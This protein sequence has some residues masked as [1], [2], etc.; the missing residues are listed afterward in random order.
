MYQGEWKDGMPHGNG[1]EFY[2][3]TGSLRYKGQFRETNWDGF[4]K[5]YTADGRKEIKGYWKDSYLTD[6]VLSKKDKESNFKIRQEDDGKIYVGQLDE[7]GQRHGFGGVYYRD[8]GSVGYEGMWKKG[9]KNGLGSSYYGLNDRDLANN[10]MYRG[11]Y[12]ENFKLRK[13]GTFYD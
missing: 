6:P 5:K 11:V 9:K 12:R 1:C 7:R 10:V 4:G 2:N 8:S 3:T 13:Q